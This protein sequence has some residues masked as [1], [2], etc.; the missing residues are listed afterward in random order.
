V[1]Y[2][3]RR[4]LYETLSEEFGSSRGSVWTLLTRTDARAVGAI[5]APVRLFQRGEPLAL[6]PFTFVR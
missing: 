6:M 5:T 3:G 1:E 2:P 4:T